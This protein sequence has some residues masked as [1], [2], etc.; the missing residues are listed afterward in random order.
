LDCVQSSCAAVL[1]CSFGLCDCAECHAKLDQP[2]AGLDRHG[3]AA[4][5]IETTERSTSL[6]CIGCAVN[7][8]TKRDEA[9]F[10]QAVDTSTLP[11]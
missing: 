7:C 3:E 6:I 5:I 2:V 10:H 4:E 9:A 1:K 8:F 11:A